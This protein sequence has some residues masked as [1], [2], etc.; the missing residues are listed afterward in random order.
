MMYDT[1]SVEWAMV[2]LGMVTDHANTLYDLWS[3]V[4]QPI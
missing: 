2:Q 4:S 3:G 1:P